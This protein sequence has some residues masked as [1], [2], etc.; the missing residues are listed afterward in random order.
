[1]NIIINNSLALRS[2]RSRTGE[3]MGD[4]SRAGLGSP[5]HAER[6]RDAARA[7]GR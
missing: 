1:M 2:L 5:V 4:D 7:V 6:E 3:N